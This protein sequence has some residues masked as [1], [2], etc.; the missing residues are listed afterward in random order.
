M[1][2][3]YA[4]Q[5]CTNG[6]RVPTK[7]DHCL[8]VNGSTSNCN[9]TSSSFNGVAGYAYTGYAYAGSYYNGGSGGYYWS[10][11][12]SSSDYAYSLAFTSGNTYPQ[13][14]YGKSLGFALR[15]V[16]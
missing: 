15:C 2:A 5:L 13:H 7:E 9:S 16:R 14:N 6:W 8:I 1:V 11:T 3:Q 4:S 10:S 12:E